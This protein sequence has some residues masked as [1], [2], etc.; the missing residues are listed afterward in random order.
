MATTHYCARCLTTFKEDPA[1]CPNLSCG[2]GRPDVGWGRLHEHGDLLDRHYLIERALAVG[3]AG[4]TYLAREI[5]AHGEPTPPDL[6]VKVLYAAR[7]SGTYLRRLANEAQILQELDHD[8]IVV[9]RGFVHR[10]G[11]EPYL[12]TL[13]EHGGSLTGH[14]ER[15]GPLAPRIA[16]GILRQVLLA[17][18]VAHQRGVVHRD[19]KPDNV[20]LGERVDPDIVPPIRVADFGIAKIESGI[21][22]QLTRLGTFLGTPEFA[23]PEQFRS[24]TPTPATDVF[25]AGGL[26]YYMLTGRPPVT[27]AERGDL[28]ASL[29]ELVR[30][31]PPRLPELPGCD[32]VELEVLDD[33]LAHTMALDPANRW[34]VHQLIARLM[35]LLGGRVSTHQTLEI[36]TEAAP[37]RLRAPPPE[38]L[39]VSEPTPSPRPVPPPEVSMSP[40]P[41]S[42]SLPEETPRGGA[43]FAGLLAGLGAAGTL[44][45]IVAGGTLALLLLGGTAWM[46][47]WFSPPGEP[48]VAL[49]PLTIDVAEHQRLRSAKVL[50][51]GGEAAQQALDEMNE[52]LDAL[53]KS[54]GQGCGA[55]GPVVGTLLVDGTGD[56]VHARIDPGYVAQHACVAQGLHGKRLP[57]RTGQPAEARVAFFVGP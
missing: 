7:A 57:N 31:L 33:V 15:V 23:A 20:L 45:V 38:R 6:A 50:L 3:G 46:S 10:T 12:V 22:S 25:A 8:N 1:R 9:C 11:H 17:L 55:A 51:G 40:E 37:E 34:T 16:A 52:A 54:V 42:S 39:R 28:E 56:I 4:I 41:T 43:G 53:G 27:F 36:T 24:E 19:L 26:L 30:S 35:V 21:T 5:D 44:A 14:V 48:L 47:G 49:A 13:F 29:T 18:D 2:H 32:P